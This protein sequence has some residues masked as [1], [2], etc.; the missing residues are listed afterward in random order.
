MSSVTLGAFATM[1][2][3]L[4]E[5]TFDLFA[6]YGV[7]VEHSEGRPDGIPQGDEQSVMAVIGFAGE[8]VRGALIL[9]ASKPAI[10]RW[11]AAIGPV[12]ARPDHYD[13]LGEFSNMLLGRL[14]GRLL[15]EGFP[16]LLSTPTTA[17]GGALR[18]MQSSCPS[19]A[20]SVTGSGWGLDVRIDA[21]FADDFALQPGD[22]RGSGAEAGDMLLF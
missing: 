2:R 4:R 12:D 21:T 7:P 11:L 18:L 6:S 19:S 8:K 17:S 3:H 9:V 5:A 1:E 13:A 14:K 16:I 20:F 15:P 10:E 22:Q